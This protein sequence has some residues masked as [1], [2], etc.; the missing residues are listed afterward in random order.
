MSELYIGLLSG[1][2]IDAIDSA[3]VDLSAGAPKIVASHSHEIPTELRE[4]LMAMTLTPDTSLAEYAVL[5]SAL[6]ELFAEAAIDLLQ[7]A[8]VERSAVTGIGSHGLTVFHAPDGENTNSLQIGNPNIIVE[9]TGITTVADMRRRDMAA[10]GQGAPLVPAFHEAVFRTPDRRRAVVNIGGIANI[11][12][13]PANAGEEAVGFDCGPGNTLLDQWIMRN[14]GEVCDR[15][16]QWARS[17]RTSDALLERLMADTYFTRRPPKSTGKEHFNLEWLTG[18]LTEL[19][20]ELPPVDVQATLVDV[21]ARGIAL[22][23]RQGIDLSSDEV[24]FCGGG[25]H[26][27]RLMEVIAAELGLDAPLPTTAALGI[28]PD[29]VEAAAFA[30][31]ACQTLT[32]RAGNLTAVTGARRSVI[33]GGVYRA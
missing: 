21:T 22:G 25:I 29:W 30:W 6:G 14:L 4:R 1:T 27:I 28:D 10:G 11:T 19:T 13:L 23:L 12:C 17:G 18:H 31:L 26:N 20:Q 33:L 24:Y 16:G 7:G 32:H 9:R 8:Q 5:D 3:L 2:S 15:D